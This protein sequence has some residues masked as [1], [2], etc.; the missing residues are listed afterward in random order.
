MPLLRAEAAKLSNNYLE[1]G[2]IEELVEKDEMFAYLPFQRVNSKA[3]VYN[4]ESESD[5]ST[6]ITADTHVKFLDV[7]ETIPEAALPFVEVT[8]K[9]RILAGDVDVDKFLIET[10][11]DTNSQLAAQLASK[12]KIIR[13]RIQYVMARGDATASP[14]EF[15]GLPNL[16][17]SAQTFAA[18]PN[19]ATLDFDMLDEL[20]DMINYGADA[21]IMHS[22]TW[23][24]M[25]TM[26]R[27]LNIVP[28]HIALP[29]VG[30]SIPVYD[31]TPIIRNDYIATNEEK[32]SSGAVCTSVYAARFNED[33]GLHGLY[34]GSPDSSFIKVEEIGTLEQKDSYRWRMKSYISACLKSTKSLARI[35]GVTLG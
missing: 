3:L 9:L 27:A 1:A 33:D 22:K 34:G 20:K 7:N 28:E 26:L 5:V 23:R 19:G 35:E 18:G 4:R 8:A 17:S 21:I 30:I 12:A 29:E 31:G 15:D 14:L 11:G 6:A 16:V 13:S 32:G 2:I 10:M 25:K 24:Y